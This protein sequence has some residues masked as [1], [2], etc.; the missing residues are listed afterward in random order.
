MLR[1]PGGGLRG[2][3]QPQAAPDHPEI[4]QERLVLDPRPVDIRP[5][6]RPAVGQGVLQ[7]RQGHVPAVFLGE[8][9]QDRPDLR[10]GAGMGPED[11][12]RREVPASAGLPEGVLGR[13]APG[14]LRV[15]FRSRR[16]RQRVRRR[17][18]VR[19]PEPMRRALWR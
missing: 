4:R 7:D 10:L 19:R 3:A 1:D 15:L 9:I 8:G 14:V 13:E 6:F 11:L 12:A 18:Q 16:G 17:Q 5:E 2:A